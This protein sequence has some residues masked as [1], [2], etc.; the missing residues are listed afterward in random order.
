MLS[1][2]RSPV[3]RLLILLIAAVI[4][5]TISLHKETLYDRNYWDF[6]Q[7]QQQQNQQQ[8]QQEQNHAKLPAEGSRERVPLIT[9]RIPISLGL[10]DGQVPENLHLTHDVAIPH[11]IPPWTKADTEML[12]TSIGHTLE[13]ELLRRDYGPNENLAGRPG[14]INFARLARAERIYKALWNHV[15]PLYQSLSGPDHMREKQ[16]FEMAKNKSEVDFFLRL[17][18]R[19]YP[20]VLHHRS[21]SFSLHGTFKGK[22]FVFCAGNRQFE[23]LVTSIQALRS[24]L[25]SELPI[26]VFHMGE[27]DLSSSRQKYLKDMTFGIE[28]VDVTQILDDS[29][30]RLGGWSIKPFAMLASTFEEVMF[31]D[32]DAYFLQDPAILFEDPGYLATGALFFFDRTLFPDQKGGSDWIKSFLP[33]MSSFPPTSRLFNYLTMH[34]QESG[35]VLINK[36]T[37]FPGLI[38]ICKMND[39]WERDL[40]SYRVFYGDKETFWIGFEMVQE[41]YAFMR[42][43]AGAIGEL[44]PDNAQSVCGALL[45][46]D[47]QGN[48]LWWNGGLYRNKNAG[49]TRNLDF[50]YWM[51]GG[52]QQQHRER[53][54]RNKEAMIEVLTDLELHSSNDLTLE[55][56]DPEWDFNESCLAGGQ[57]HTLTQRE[58]DLANGYIGIDKIAR[59]DGSKM[60]RGETPDPT[61]HDWDTAAV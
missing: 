1:L 5:L 51:S 54:T 10:F 49:V 38:S 26:Q 15:Y 23:F 48:P 29:Y 53:Y 12:G 4:V 19:L 18:R 59:E 8:Q 47:H 52:G 3:F 43:Y 44:R 33:I 41:P 36:K 22:G 24:R 25:K 31:I 20:W 7:Q 40:Y 2:P 61:Q 30:I 45:H 17:E 60:D 39:K 37:R 46:Q 27:N 21:T 35:V 58:K 13:A 50:G 16:L 56:R 55:P 28:I 57:V 34:E 32:A 42:N 6:S 11:N 9:F 14:R